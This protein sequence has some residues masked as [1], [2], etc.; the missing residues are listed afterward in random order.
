M[1]KVTKEFATE[2]EAIAWLSGSSQ[3]GNVL[4]DVPAYIAAAP[5]PMYPTPAAVAPAPQYA[6]P[7]H[8]A[9]PAPVATVPVGAPVTSAAPAVDNGGIT[10]AQIGAAAQAYSKAYKAAA[11]KAVFAQFGIKSVGE[12][13]PDQYPQLLA[14]LQVK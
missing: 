11:T 12:A 3:G 8:M 6:A 4:A 9:A 14:A 7:A 5:A 2:A 13:R 1:I 10:A